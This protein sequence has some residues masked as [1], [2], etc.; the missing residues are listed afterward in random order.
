MILTD[1]GVNDHIT[2]IAQQTGNDHCQHYDNGG[3]GNGIPFGFFYLFSGGF[4]GVI[5][6][7]LVFY[8]IF[9]I[10]V[11]QIR[12]MLT[13]AQIYLI[14]LY[15]IFSHLSKYLFFLLKIFRN[16]FGHQFRAVFGFG[17]GIQIGPH[18]QQDAVGG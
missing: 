16:G 12:H 13:P 1:L 14:I 17:G 7:D 10:F 11:F 15:Y 4:F 9:F 3:T 18:F 8:S 5:R 6:R 2:N